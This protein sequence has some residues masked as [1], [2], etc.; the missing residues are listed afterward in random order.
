MKAIETKV[1]GQEAASA[2]LSVLPSK[3]DRLIFLQRTTIALLFVSLVC[4]A[5]YAR[6]VQNRAAHWKAEAARLQAQIIQTALTQA[7]QNETAWIQN[8][9]T[10]TANDTQRPDWRDEPPLQPGMTR[11]DVERVLMPDGGP[12]AIGEE[13]YIY[14][15]APATDPGASQKVVKVTIHFLPNNLAGMVNPSFSEPRPDDI[16]TGISAPYLEEGY[17]N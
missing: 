7:E 13:R 11:A 10:E 15:V 3:R 1:T 16:I 4:V 5:F 9:A 2:D 12:F 8:A 6:A 14:P 17:S